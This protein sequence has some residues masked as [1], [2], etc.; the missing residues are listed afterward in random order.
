MVRQL[1]WVCVTYLTRPAVWGAAV[2]Y[3]AILSQVLFTS[4]RTNT[5]RPCHPRVTF[6]TPA[7][8]SRGDLEWLLAKGRGG[9]NE[10]LH[11]QLS[12][13]GTSRQLIDLDASFGCLRQLPNLRGLSLDY[14]PISETALQSVSHMDRLE[15]LS[16]AGTGIQPH[17]LHHLSS[18]KRLK[19][20][21]LSQCDFAGGLHHLTPLESLDTLILSSFEHLNDAALADLRH[22]PQLQTLVIDLLSGRDPERF[23]TERGLQTLASLPNLRT[24]YVSDLRP[25]FSLLEPLRALRPHA[26][27]R[28]AHYHEGRI[29]RVNWLFIASVFA[30]LIVAMHVASQFSQPSARLLPHFTSVHLAV[31]AAAYAVATVLHTGLLFQLGAALCPAAVVCAAVLGVSGLAF[32]VTVFHWPP[33][34]ARQTILGWVGAVGLGGAVPLYLVSQKSVAPWLDAYLVGDFALVTVLA[35]CA[36][37]LVAGSLGR[38]LCRLAPR[39]SEAGIAPPI[40]MLDFNTG[41]PRLAADAETQT[42]VAGES[43]TD[44]GL[45]D[46]SGPGYHENHLW[47]RIRLWRAGN[48]LGFGRLLALSAVVVGIGVFAAYRNYLV[49][50]RLQT[51]RTGLSPLVL[52][53][54]ILVLAS[55]ATVAGA[56]RRRMGGLAYE[57]TR[58]LT[59]ET[60]RSDLFLA[61]AWD[62][63]G[64][65]PGLIALGCLALAT[66]PPLG[67]HS[68]LWIT[69]IGAVFLGLMLILYSAV[70]WGVLIRSSWLAVALG[71]AVYLAMVGLCGAWFFCVHQRVLIDPRSLLIGGVGLLLAGAFALDRAWRHW[72]RIELG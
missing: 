25:G 11:F 12:A 15:S 61:I 19:M 46:I 50:G 58:P 17:Q 14:L 16:L 71:C 39:F 65:L 8:R 1:Q 45:A 4:T 42:Q 20:L 35:G 22:L 9:D 67:S 57:S 44:R 54:G 40:S 64:V 10:F 69:A 29:E 3:A 41:R 36:G 24:I 70:V 52:C 33:L 34:A 30:S 51:T 56:W 66:S 47:R 13:F 62:L 60:I 59:R 23:V 68:P 43:T 37:L 2:I 38:A 28:R 21:D 31:P 26:T 27:V 7:V 6:P 53:G 48:Q 5:Y 55:A 63:A 18:L 32:F 49:G 72:L